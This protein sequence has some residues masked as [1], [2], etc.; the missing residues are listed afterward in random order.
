MSIN[1]IILS[2]RNVREVNGIAS[3]AVVPGDL[4]ERTTSTA[5]GLRFQK[6]SSTLPTPIYV[7]LESV[8]ST[9]KTTAQSIATGADIR[10]GVLSPGDRFYARLTSGNTITPGARLEAGTSGRVTAWTK[11][12]TAFA[13][14]ANSQDLSTQIRQVIGVSHKAQ[15]VSSTSAA[16]RIEVE[17][18]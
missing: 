18:L 3:G 5:G 10:V 8:T 16:N 2:G 1:T 4:L 15:T 6:R 13:T 14:S 12:S 11:P 7:A 17:V 9:A